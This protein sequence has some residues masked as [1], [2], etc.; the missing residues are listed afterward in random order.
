MKLKITLLLLAAVLIL[1]TAC[2]APLW[3]SYEIFVLADGDI[4][5]GPHYCIAWERRVT[6]FYCEQPGGVEKV[7]LE[8][9]QVLQVWRVNQVLP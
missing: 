5:D 1:T 2:D 8:E 9:G 7:E 3:A 4:V 6:T